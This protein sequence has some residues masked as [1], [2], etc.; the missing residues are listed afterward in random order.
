MRYE[1]TLY[2]PEHIILSA[3]LAI[4]LGGLTF[5]F[6]SGR[7]DDERFMTYAGWVVSTAGAYLLGKKVSK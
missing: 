2:C 5:A 4:V 6:L 7:I 3:F 1:K